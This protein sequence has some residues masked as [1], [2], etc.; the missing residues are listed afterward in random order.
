MFLTLI[1]APILLLICFEHFCQILRGKVRGGVKVCSFLYCYSWSET[2]WQI[3]LWQRWIDSRSVEN[4]NM[5][6]YNQGKP[7]AR[8][9][10]KNSFLERKRSSEGCS[11]QSVVFQLLSP[12]QERSGVFLLPMRLCYQRGAWEHL[13]LVPQ[14]YLISFSLLIFLFYCTTQNLPNS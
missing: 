6:V 10:K 11:K 2:N 1:K 4:S 14:F 7:C 3:F 13:L 5:G 12:C 9:G 8:Q